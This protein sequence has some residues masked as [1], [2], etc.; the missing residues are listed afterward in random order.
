M[1]KMI[2]LLSAFL[3]LP[4]FAHP[5]IIFQTN[6]DNVPTWNPSGAGT[7]AC[8]QNLTNDGLNCPAGPLPSSLFSD[9]RVQD[10]VC[11]KIYTSHI[12]SASDIASVIA[13]GGQTSVLPAFTPYGGSGK[14]YVHF[15]EPCMS[16]S[17]GWGSD[18]QLGVYF[19][20][21]TGY[22]ELYIQYMVQFMPGFQWVA[23]GVTSGEGQGEQQKLAH[24][25]HVDPTV[26]AGE[27]SEFN[28]NTRPDFV[29][30]LY[31]N[32]HWWPVPQAN[33][34]YYPFENGSTNA[35]AE[36]PSSPTSIN[37]SDGNWHTIRYHVKLNTTAGLAN[38][39]YSS[40][41]VA[42]FW[43]DG[44]LQTSKSNIAWTLAATPN[45][46]TYGFNRIDIGGNSDNTWLP[47]TDGSV[48]MSNPANPACAATQSC[49]NQWYA[50]D[51]MVVF[52]NSGDVPATGY[53]P[54]SDIAPIPNGGSSSDTTPP[55][56]PTGLRVK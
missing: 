56:A 38:N 54:V 29:P 22:S 25:M 45:A 50:L 6:F 5:A 39:I 27:F 42:E 21:S 55:A 35:S 30:A 1:V 23:S 19:G 46:A 52:T 33:P 28:T 10:H 31:M 8:W 37:I 49:A 32:T 43:I 18:G 48:R 17:G 53:V 26:S 7:P 2:F 9:Y 4:K 15:Y 47:G 13:T 24:I 34:V 14:S 12:G 40:N 44:V 3:I 11:S 51:N 41:G 16:S 20:K 36:T